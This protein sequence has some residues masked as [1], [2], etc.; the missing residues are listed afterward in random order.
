MKILK[1]E[2]K[3]GLYMKKGSDYETID[4]IT[5]E[6]L[7]DLIEFVVDNNETEFDDSSVS[8]I[9]NPAQKI[10]Y[11]NIKARLHEI[12]LQRETISSNKNKIYLEAIEKYGKK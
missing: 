3:K 5:K 7:F 2:D 12:K 11:D 1:I 4:K 9:V 8:E 10:I 6:E